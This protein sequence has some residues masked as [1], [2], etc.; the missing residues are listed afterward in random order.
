MS[1]PL[2]IAALVNAWC[3][4]FWCGW[5]L[6]KREVERAHAEFNRLV[7]AIELRKERER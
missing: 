4:G 6:R 3:A 5:Y 1:E 2:V 7:D